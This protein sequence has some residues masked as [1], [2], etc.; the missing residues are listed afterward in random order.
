MAQSPELL[1]ARILIVDD[2]PNTATM[3]ARVLARIHYPVEVFTA[4]SGENALRQIVPFCFAFP[5]GDLITKFF[6]K[7]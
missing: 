4:D 2:H 1:P 5:A 7:G 3:L 6:F